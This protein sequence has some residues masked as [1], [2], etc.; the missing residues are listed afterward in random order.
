MQCFIWRENSLPPTQH[1]ED[2]IGSP[3]QSFDHYFSQCRG[4]IFRESAKLSS[5]GPRVI[6]HWKNYFLILSVNEEVGRT[7]GLDSALPNRSNFWESIRIFS[8]QK[9][10]DPGQANQK[11]LCGLHSRK[12]SKICLSQPWS[13]LI[14]FFSI[15]GFPANFSIHSPISSK[16]F[17]R[18]EIHSSSASP[19]SSAALATRKRRGKKPLSDH[20]R[21]NLI[22]ENSFI[23]C[24][25]V[26]RTSRFSFLFW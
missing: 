15:Q 8:K 23:Y 22:R 9:T 26:D 19:E 16:K 17:D 18:I 4:R 6:S 11:L 13:N 3:P 21:R 12:S 25:A 20:Q 14:Q 10:C 2:S 1:T 24:R 7:A 5:R